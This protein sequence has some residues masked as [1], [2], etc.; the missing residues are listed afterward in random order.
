MQ[1]SNDGGFLGRLR[2]NETLRKLTGGRP[3][4]IIFGAPI[5]AVVIAI[6]A[7]VAVVS[8]SGGGDSDDGGQATA[9]TA[10]R[11]ATRTPAGTATPG[12][13]LGAKTPIAFSEGDFLTDADLAARGVGEPGRGPFAGQR[14]VIPSIGVD[15]PFTV[16]EVGTDGQ[17][18][19]PNGPEDVAWYDFSQWPG[20]GGLPLADGDGGNVVLAGHVDYINYGPA[21]FWRLDEL[22]TGDEIQIVMADG[23]MATYA[24]EFSKVVDPGAADWSNLVAATADESVTLI[25][26]TGEFEAGH[27]TNRHIIWG[28]R[29]A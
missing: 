28:R 24:V 8:A 25:T 11:S 27:Y 23:T 7:T 3:D 18:P 26:C 21:V 22:K 29:I 2:E 15:A 13:N 6:A 17:M 1:G 4:L 9:P 10:T 16:K 19:N 5:L 14:L 12:S 20:L